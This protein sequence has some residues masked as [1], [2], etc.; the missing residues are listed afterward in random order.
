MT[1]VHFVTL[2][3]S[4]SSLPSQEQ[5]SAL[6]SKKEVENKDNVG[7]NVHSSGRVRCRNQTQYLRVACEIPKVPYN[8]IIAKTPMDEWKFR[9]ASH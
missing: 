2:S 5:N 7:L 3:L 1:G 6:N 9:N 8:S 4:L